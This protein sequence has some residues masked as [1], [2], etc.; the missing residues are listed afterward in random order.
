MKYIKCGLLAL[1]ATV[2][3]QGSTHDAILLRHTSLFKEILN[4]NTITDHQVE[5]VDLGT[6]PL[7]SVGGRGFFT[8]SWLLKAYDFET[9]DSQQH[10]FNKCNCGTRVVC[11]NAYD[12]LKRRRR[13]QIYI[14]RQGHKLS[15]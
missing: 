6:I 13:W 15:F 11:E 14:K 9:K 12:V 3:I 4:G 7:I 8:F 10:F 2:G 1:Y 5:L